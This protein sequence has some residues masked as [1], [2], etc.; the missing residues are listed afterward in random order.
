[1]NIPHLRGLSHSFAV[2]ESLPP[3]V[4]DC[5]CCVISQT[6]EHQEACY[7]CPCS[8][9]SCVTVH[10]DYVLYIPYTFRYQFFTF[11][12]LEHL[13]AYFEKNVHSWGVMIFPLLFNDHVLELA[14]VVFP[15]AQIEDQVMV[16][17]SLLQESRNLSMINQFATL[18]NWT[19]PNQQLTSL[20]LFLYIYSKPEAGKLMPHTLLVT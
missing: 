2:L 3:I 18:F 11:K 19:Y 12:E 9:L 10:N 20:I 8:S 5:I 13:L 1:M 17:V 4:G 7:R 16:F 6:T 14:I 15:A